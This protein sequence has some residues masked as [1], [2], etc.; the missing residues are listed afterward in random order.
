MGFAPKGISKL[1]E[2][3]I[4]ANKDWAIKGI[5]S[6][7]YVIIEDGAGHYLRLSQL[8]TAQRD[9]LTPVAGM[10]I[11]NSTTGQAERYDGADWGPMGISGVSVRKNTT[12]P[13]IGT[14]PQLNFIEGV[15]VDI[16]A[17]DNPP[18][19]EIDLTFSSTTPEKFI[20]LVPG[21]AALPTANP[22][23]KAVVNGTNFAYDV[24]DFDPDTEESCNWEYYLSPDYDGENIVVDI[25][26]I[27]ADAD[28]GHGV[29]WGVKV[30]G[31]E[32][33]ETWDN[34]LGSEQ[35]VVSA[36]PGA[37]KLCR[38]RVSTFAPG[39]AAGDVVLFKLA[40]KA[41][42]VD[43]DVDQ[44]ARVTKVVV[45]Y[46]TSF[47]QSF[48]PITPVL[49]TSL[50]SNAWTDLDLSDYM[51]SGATGAI[52][53]IK[54]IGAGGATCSFR[55][56]G[57]TDDFHADNSIPVGYHKWLMSG[58]DDNRTCQY[59]MAVPALYFEVYLI[60]YTATG[61]IFFD[62]AVNKVLGADDTWTNVDLSSECPGAIG[63]ILQ[64]QN[65]I[66]AL[67]TF[68]CRRNGSTDNR[69]SGN[70]THIQP[71]EHCLVVVGCDDSQI[72][73]AAY[74]GANIKIYIKGYI[75]SGAVFNTN[76]EDV[77]PSAE[78]TWEESTPTATKPTMAFIEL[79]NYM[80]GRL[81]AQKNGTSEDMLSA[82]MHNWAVVEVDANGKLELYK[83][84]LGLALMFNS[85]YATHAD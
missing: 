80:G 63:I 51:P 24:L 2:L 58:L 67:K 37:G 55:K 62:N 14:R 60:G 59:Y 75:I 32:H 12:M 22:A 19:D 16:L 50:V 40:R 76:G 61:V 72:I 26:W 74:Q 46:T 3:E 54:S 65:E 28:T 5:D 81:G 71:A 27:T 56:K 44:D 48:Y 25:F 79:C 36:N 8:T 30:L 68:G 52:F 78:D 6:L 66:G 70:G 82:C 17:E 33:G 69:K 83:S 64:F 42:E 20:V 41:A 49:L 45:R 18:D 85:G 15:G 39:W 11:W 7:A 21:E 73:Q 23:A 13:V 4:D 47:A 35:S 38:S 57:S 34:A 10:I 43:D 77:T 31:R 53:H 9:A 29:H 84:W 1:S